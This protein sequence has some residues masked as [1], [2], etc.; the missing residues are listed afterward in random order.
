MKRLPAIMTLGILAATVALVAVAADNVGNPRPGYPHDTIIIHVLSDQSG[1]KACDGGHSLF[2]RHTGG[3]IPDTLMYITMTD[4]NQMDND[5]DGLVDEDPTVDGIDQDGDG[6]DGE[7]PLE[8]GAI[9]TALDCDS[10]GDGTV[11]LQ[12]R[13]T[14]PR[15]GW[16]STQE[17]F[18]RLIGKPGQNFA[19]TSF[20][21][22]TVSCTVL[23]DPDTIPNSG[24]ETVTCTSGTTADWV[25]LASFNLRDLGCVKTVKLGGKGVQAGGKTPFCNITD[26]FSVD[27]DE[28]NDGVVDYFDQ[29]VFSVGC[30]DN[31]LTPDV[32]EALY[33]PLSS[34]IWD[35]DEEETTSQAKAQIFVAHTGAAQ[36]RSGKIR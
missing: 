34:I 8:P 22:Q 25:H 9:T 4:W 1:P 13:D 29:F 18:M 27:V 16:V 36:I 7:D 35:V 2:L 10:Y 11:K 20:A 28:T 19:F 6:L 12:I 30:V 21:N 33:C 26:G 14:D 24:D 5:G 32:N 17:W 31:P 3:V 15:P 23:S